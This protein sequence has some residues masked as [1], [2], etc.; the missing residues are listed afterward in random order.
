[1][2]ALLA[3]V[4]VMLAATLLISLTRRL[5]DAHVSRASAA[6]VSLAEASGAD[7]VAFL[8]AEFGFGA[9]SEPL[10][11]SLA[12]VRTEFT[13]EETG[14]AGIRSGFYPFENA[15]E[16]VLIPSG[17]RLVSVMNSDESTVTI[18]FY[19]GE[20]F[21]STAEFS[22]ETDMIPAGGTPIV[23]Q[24]EEGVVVVLEGQSS[25]ML[26]VVTTQGIQAQ[27]V[28]NH[29]VLSSRSLM[30]AGESQGG[31]PLLIVTSGGNHGALYDCET[32]DVQRLT[33]PPRTCP[34]FLPDGSIFGSFTQGHSSF[35][36]SE[37]RDVFSG[38]FNNDGRD[39]MAFATSFSLSVYSGS[40]GNL[41]FAGPG[42]ALVAWGS[43]DGRTG[44]C[45]MW[46]MPDGSEKWL[47]LCYD[48]FSEF[49][50]EMMFEMGWD[51]RFQGVG[52]T[53]TGIIDGSAVVA[54]SSGS[55][56]EL[57]TG[58]VFTGDADGGDIDF[59]LTGEH[60]VEAYFNPERGDGI[61]L[62]LS[63]ENVFRGAKTTGDNH[64]FSIYE[65]GGERRVF[66]SLEGLDS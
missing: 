18:S 64:V 62:K 6:Q 13:L 10:Q 4:V 14:S 58:D 39:D 52:N 35:S 29:I 30:S 47:R 23:F 25:S 59:F 9:V 66:H 20:T 19:S 48:G 50:P 12:G 36:I 28:V 21:Q 63:T 61:S 32:G 11:F 51:G 3:A 8:L 15:D 41:I 40:T 44:L 2:I 22:M 45:G 43:V 34:V 37:I 27:V 57:L 38:D 55:I 53:V 17:N 42:G 24:G 5:V 46:R 33:S 26:C 65:S 1:M 16:A 60:G 7:G 49:D 31:T 54:S 56:L